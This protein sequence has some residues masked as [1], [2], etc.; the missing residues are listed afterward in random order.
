ML[1]GKCNTIVCILLGYMLG[2][3]SNGKVTHHPKLLGFLIICIPEGW[4][5]S[6]ILKVF[7]TK[8]GGEHYGLRHPANKM[9]K[10]INYAS[11]GPIGLK[12]GQRC[13]FLQEITHKNVSSLAWLVKKL[14]MYAS[15]PL[16]HKSNTGY[17]LVN[18]YCS[19]TSVCVQIPSR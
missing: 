12:I 13:G 1:I 19:T 2:R 9:T 4:I 7:T 3:R 6:K 16:R 17:V 18:F 11:S 14:L 10:L 8:T 15:T 5:H